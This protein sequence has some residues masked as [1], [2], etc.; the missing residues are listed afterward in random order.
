MYKIIIM[1]LAIGCC[2]ATIQAQTLEPTTTSTALGI[3]VG[4]IIPTRGNVSGYVGLEYKHIIKTKDDIAGIYPKYGKLAIE[5][6]PA[7]RIQDA[8]WLFGIV[9]YERT[10]HYDRNDMILGFGFE[11]KYVNVSAKSLPSLDGEEAFNIWGYD[12]SFSGYYKFIGLGFGVQQDHA[13]T[14][15]YIKLAFRFLDG[16]ESNPCRGCRNR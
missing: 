5:A 15:R 16:E 9:G 6:G 12:L 4:G 10:F 11:N 2:I 1:L 14:I 3:E 7:F 8:A 13:C